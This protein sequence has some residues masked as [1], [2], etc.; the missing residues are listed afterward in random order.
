VAAVDVRGGAPGTIN[1]DALRLSYDTP[2]LD[3]ITFAGGSSYG[4]SV[5]TGVAEELKAGKAN[6]GEWDNIATVAGA[7]IFDFGLRFNT[8][9]PDADLGRAAFRTARA[10][11]FP[12][13]AR[14]AG[15]FATQGG[16][17]DGDRQHSGQGGAF[18]Q[19]GPTKIVIF[20]VV[21]SWGAVVNREGHVLRCQQSASPPPACGAI[22]DLLRRRMSELTAAQA[23]AP[24]PAPDSTYQGTTGNT[25]LTLVVTDQQLPYSALQRLAVQVHSSLARAIQPFS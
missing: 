3:A 16:Y 14:G 18:R 19:V 13:G 7:V 15:R 12:L 5:A 9:T 1:T 4:L 11:W 23:A 21:N 25:T 6:S 24:S 2:F 20:T 8:V 22:D 10:G 17:F